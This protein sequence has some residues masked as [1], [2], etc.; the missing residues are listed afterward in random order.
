MFDPAHLWRGLSVSIETDPSLRNKQ[1]VRKALWVLGVSLVMIAAAS[2]IEARQD[3][4]NGPRAGKYHILSYGA[5]GRPPLALGWF[6]LSG[7]TKYKAYLPGDVLSGSG[8]YRYDAAKK[9]VIWLT[10]PHVKDWGG[11]FTIEREGKTHAIRLRRGT[12]ATNSTDSK[13]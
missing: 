4:S 10:G 2:G 1:M 11:D 7:G 12:S 13:R 5:P 6:E 8:T 3:A 9:V